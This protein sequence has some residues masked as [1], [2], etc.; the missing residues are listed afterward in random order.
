MNLQKNFIQNAKYIMNE[1]GLSL[2]EMKRRTGMHDK[3]FRGILF[4]DSAV[5][6]RTV[7]RISDALGVDPIAMM[8]E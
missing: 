1:K 8:E 7:Q 4:H 2:S 3:H 5:T 6:L